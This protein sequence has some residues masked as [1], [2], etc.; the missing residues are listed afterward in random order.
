M[1][2]SIPGLSTTTS[3]LSPD[4]VEAIELPLAKAT[5]KV[6]ASMQVVL[7]K[8][9]D[10]RDKVLGGVGMGG[11]ISAMEREAENDKMGHLRRMKAAEVRV[12]RNLKELREP[13]EVER[14]RAEELD[15]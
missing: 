12:V 2:A 6:L 11:E 1:V 5:E 13:R 15:I 4:D 8:T 10:E 7:E 14:F 3:W 9:K